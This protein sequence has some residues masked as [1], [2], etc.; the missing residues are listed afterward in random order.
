MNKL[1][2]MR[3]IPGSGKSTI[4]RRLMIEHLSKRGKSLAICSTDD[5]H[6]EGDEYVF[7]ADKLGEFHL[8]NQRRAHFLMSAGIELVIIDNTNIRRKDMRTYVESAENF[9]YTVEEIIVGED[10]L[11]PDLDDADPHKF[12]D[13]IDMC[14]RRNTHGVPH[15][16]IERM[17]RSFQL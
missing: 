12:T 16:A 2:L 10:E 17:A 11:F 9:R 6:M 1:V 3:G 15:E 14:A 13:Y 5:Y 7:K 8:A 4:A